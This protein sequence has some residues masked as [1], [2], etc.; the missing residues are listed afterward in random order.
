MLISLSI[1]ELVKEDKNF[2]FQLRLIR[3][4]FPKDKEL[5]IN[6]RKAVRGVVL[7]DDK[8]MMVH[9]SLGDYKFPG[10]GIGAY[11]EA[12][13]ALLREIRE[14][15]G[16]VDITVGP[17]IGTALEQ[18]LDNFEADAMFQMESAYYLCKLNSMA[19]VER[20]LEQYEKDMEFTEMFISVKEAYEA[21]HML[22]LQCENQ[23]L[24]TIGMKANDWL[25]RETLA[26]E[27]IHNSLVDKLLWDV[28]ECGLI[29]KNAD[30]SIVHVTG[31]EGHGNFVTNYDKM[32]QTQLKERLLRIMPKAT[33]VGEEDDVHESIKEGYAFIVDP[34]DGTTNFMKDYNQ[35]CISVGITY[36]GVQVGGI[37][38]QPYL[39]E[40]F[41][42]EKDKGAYR[43]GE[44]IHVSD[45]DLEHALVV[46][47]TAPY[48]EDLTKKSFAKAQEVFPYCIDVRR[49]G[50]AAI[51]LCNVA[52]G[53]ADMYFEYLICPWD[54]AAGSLIVTEAGGFIST[55]DGKPITLED[56]CSI[57]AT[58]G[59]TAL[60]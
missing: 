36:E 22:L 20:N 52:A 1:F 50:S 18:N 3:D 17:C 21:N 6:K 56:K 43:N 12:R 48:Y 32:I 55:I 28:Y 4:E 30:R 14:E 51:D 11:E 49:S 26:L 5:K 9:T 46:F 24:E 59:V 41:C 47:G 54:I 31:K 10:G 45:C 37:V 58:N 29:M 35:S 8:L 15:T 42:A 34:I 13:Y 25:E 7:Y 16:Y 2:M 38:Y 44:A 23:V 60:P 19:K 40:M 39:D 53:R 27:A 33:F 57:L